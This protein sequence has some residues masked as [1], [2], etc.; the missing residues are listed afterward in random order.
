M[1]NDNR[2]TGMP[3]HATRRSF[4]R[5]K[6]APLPRR[7]RTDNKTPP[8]QHRTDNESNQTALM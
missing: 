5:V 8:S 3:I 1:G 6:E 2:H 4:L 7:D